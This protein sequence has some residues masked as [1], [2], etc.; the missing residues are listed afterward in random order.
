[1]HALH[2][3]LLQPPNVRCVIHINIRHRVDI[4][5]G[6]ARGHVVVIN[7]VLR[8]AVINIV[9]A[10]FELVIQPVTEISTPDRTVN[11]AVILIGRAAYIDITRAVQRFIIGV[12][13]PERLKAVITPDVDSR[14]GKAVIIRQQ[15]AKAHRR[16]ITNIGA[17]TPNNPGSYVILGTHGSGLGKRGFSHHR[18][19]A[20]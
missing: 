11:V 20:R 12:K 8:R 10:V 7:V 13:L 2:R 19:D 15:I 17:V 14:D 1:M 16:G 5:S 6:I 4:V 18:E 9:S 3:R